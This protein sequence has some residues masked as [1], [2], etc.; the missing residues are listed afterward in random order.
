M[1]DTWARELSK[2]LV[3]TKQLIAHNIVSMAEAKQ[4]NDVNNIFDMRVPKI[5]VEHIQKA[6]PSIQKQFIPDTKELIF[7]PEELSNPIG[8]ETYSPTEGITHRYPNRVLL[9]P[10]YMCASYCRFCFRRYKV[11]NSDYNLS[12]TQYTA[13]LDYIKAHKEVWEVILTGGD[14][15]VLTDNYLSQIIADLSAIEH[16]KIIRFHSRIPSVLP[17]RITPKLI[18][19]LK[20]SGKTIWIVAHLN[21]ADEFT[22]ECKTALNLLIDNGIPVIM[23]SVLLKGINDSFEALRNLFETAVINRVRPYYLHYPDLAK[24]THHFRIPLEDAQ[25]L[26]GS[27]RGQISGLCLPTFV[28]DIPG[29]FG[30]ISAEKSRLWQNSDGTWALDSPLK[31]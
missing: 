13:C 11:S 31:K 6:N 28:L 15:L 9:K 16:L 27:L 14:P 17:Q 26:F 18:Q 8:D 23:Q 24:G 20:S 10:T 4:L 3:H 19:I 1:N 25:K 21:S 22:A 12:S 5:F 2:G 30:K 29:G 7:L